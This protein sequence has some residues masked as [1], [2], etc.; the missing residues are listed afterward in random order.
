MLSKILDK[1][2]F[3]SLACVLVL[4]P[5]FFLPSTLFSLDA[6]KTSLTIFGL[7]VALIAFVV[8]RFSDGKVSFPKSIILL[9]GFGLLVVTFLSALF[10]SAT[11]MSFFGI[12]LDPGSF[13]FMLVGFLLM[14]V[15]SIVF[16]NTTRMKFLFVWSVI[17]SILLMIFQILHIFFPS[18]FSLNILVEK[19]DNLLGSWN[20]FGIFTGLFA[21]VA[22]FVTEFFTISGFKKFLLRLL[23]VV[24]IVLSSLVNFYLIW[25]LLG[26]FAL[27]VFV[28]KIYFSFSNKPEENT[29]KSFPVFPF[30]I[31]MFSLLFFMSGKF[32]GGFLPQS[33]GVSN[34]EVYPS[35][36]T[37][38]GITKNVLKSDPIFGVGPNRFADSWTMYKP[39]NINNSGFWN[40]SFSFGSGLLPTF[41]SSNGILGI[42]SWLVFLAIFAFF[43]IKSFFYSVKK[44]TN[45]EATGFFIAALYLFTA[46]FFYPVNGV[47]LFMAFAFTGVFIGLHSNEHPNGIFSFSFLDDP[48]KSFSLILLLVLIMISASALTFQYGKI[49][50]SV[51]YYG[52]AV[53]S[54][55]INQAESAIN[56]AVLLHKNDLYLRTY[57]QLYLTK[58]NTLVSKN[59]TLSEKEKSD[60]QKSFDEAVK[61]ANLA[62]QY[63]IKNYL[64]H[65]SLGTVYY[66]AGLLGVKDAYEKA[67]ESF[68]IASS[69]NPYN[70]S[71]K[72][73]LARVSF[74]EDNIKDARALSTEA[75]SLKPDYIDALVALSQIEKKAGNS[76]LAISY[77]ER[78]LSLDPDNSDLSSFLKST[79]SN[80]NTNTSEELTDLK[81][82]KNN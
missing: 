50:L 72:L 14:F 77:A 74:A 64:N 44:N 32:V 58:M 61:G 34:V 47:M 35:F 8:A 60:L 43:G 65:E 33:L 12:M 36:G 37:T 69:L 18:M 24:A 31:V 75:L 3:I 51:P 15:S 17:I 56:K 49:F 79:K 42:L 16:K 66:T 78:A 82:D 19:T 6:S 48:R 4:L 10:S 52:K 40:T 70:P 21:I 13:Y 22:L 30:L 62:V 7:F 38:L 26:L 27:V 9:S 1:V 76:S 55:D 2:S 39:M 41:M 68:N 81:K 45:W 63:N 25:I 29:K 20:T 11:K 53:S 67:K 46:S 5:V 59:S 73:S 57:V 71:L 54:T 23:V 28:Y 80:N